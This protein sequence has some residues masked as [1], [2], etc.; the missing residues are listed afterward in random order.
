[1]STPET[2]RKKSFP[3]AVGEKPFVLIL[4][5]MPGEESLRQQQYYAYKYNSFWKIMGELFA[6]N[7]TLP[8]EKRIHELTE[9]HVALWDV[10]SSCQREGSLDTSIKDTVPNDI[11]S[12][13][14]KHPSIRV[15]F[16][17]GG[18][19]FQFLKKYF[20]QLFQSGLTIERLPSTSPAA[21]AVSYSKKLEAFR[22]IKSVIEDQNP[23]QN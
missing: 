1:M 20:P 12:L 6:F 15:V 14:K 9:N 18:A 10:L 8:Y 2:K 16:C 19:S 13:L 23:S 5:S 21:A 11:P 22:K 7:P 4:G 3:P 17:N